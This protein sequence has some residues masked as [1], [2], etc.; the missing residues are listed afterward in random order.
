MTFN[1]FKAEWI[2]PQLS[3]GPV[4]FCFKGSW[5]VF[6]IFV[7]IL[8]QSVSKYWRPWSDAA[9]YGVWAGSALFAYDP[10]IRG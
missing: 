6:F 10:Q 2:F 3:I 9:F 7:K 8:E 4:Q 1:P 5:V